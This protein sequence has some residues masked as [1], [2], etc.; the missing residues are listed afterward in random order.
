MKRSPTTT[1]FS[2]APYLNGCNDIRQSFVRT[3]LWITLGWYDFILRYRRTF[4]GPV[5]EIITVVIWITGLGLIYGRLFNYSQETYLAYLTIGIILWL[6]IS[7]T[8]TTG[9]NVFVSNAAL[10][11][12][13]NNP[14]YT[15]VL[16]NIIARLIRLMFH[17]LV[18]I[19]MLFLI[20][21][22][23]VLRPQ[24][25]MVLPGFFM[26]L[27]MSL[28]LIPLLGFFGAKFRDLIY[29]IQACMRFLFFVTPVFWYVENLG[30]RTFLANV[31]PFTHFLA[32]VRAPLLGEPVLHHS[33]LVVL[34]I[35]TVGFIVTVILYGPYRQRL[36]YWL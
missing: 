23:L 5:W 13:I 31:N 7:D 27:F 25:F 33:W 2:K 28:W 35:N 1:N 9:V 22:D 4:L 20:K 29:L 10:I 32:V 3:P 12:S 21:I 16:R 17:S 11:S 24:T 18:F 15:Y 26:L 34:L 6:Y 8:L 19:A 14:L 30:S 36:I